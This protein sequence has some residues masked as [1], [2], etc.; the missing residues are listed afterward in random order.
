MVLRGRWCDT[1]VLNAHAPT[2]DK[3]VDP[4]DVFVQSLN[5]RSEHKVKMLEN[6]VLRKVL[7][8]LK[9]KVAEE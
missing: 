3:N 9:K 4:K 5:V 2:V 8:P 7:G 1:T 6:R